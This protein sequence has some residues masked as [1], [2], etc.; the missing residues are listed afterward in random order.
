MN[1]EPKTTIKSNEQLWQRIAL[2]AA[3]FSFVVCILLIANYIQI[4][5]ADPVN[6]KVINALV[7][8]LNQNPNDN[9][10]RDQIRELDL[11]SRKAYFTSQWQI[12]A[13]GYMV[14]IGLA[15]IIIA[16]QMISL[17]KKKEP[18]VTTEF[19]ENSTLAQK[20]ARRWIAVFGVGI[21]ALALVFA[22]LSQND[23]NKKF[24]VAA[25]ALKSQNATTDI[26]SAQ[27]E[28]VST[29]DTTKSANVQTDNVTAS[30]SVKAPS[31][32]DSKDNYPNFRGPGGTARAAQKNI[33]VS[34]NGQSGKNVLWKTA[35]PLSGYNSPIIW[36]SKI[37]LT[38]A[39]ATKREVYC[40][41]KNT[42][43]ILWTTPFDKLPSSPG[44]APKVNSETG[45]A[46]STAA[47]DGKGVYAIFP[48][49]DIIG[50]D[51]EGKKLWAQNLGDPQNHYGHASSL[52]VYKDMVIIQF[53]QRNS[54]K[55]MALSTKTGKTVWNTIR[56][57][58]ISWASPIIVNTGKR[59]EIILAAE[60]Y[61]AAY[62]PANG[63]E[64]W[65]IDCISGE[66]GPSVAYANGMVFSVNDY[67]KLA[68]IKLGDSPKIL[69]ESTDF[70]SDIPSPV[71]TDKYVFLVTSYGTVVCY[72]AL[73][74][75]KY[76]DKEMGGNV[77]ASPVITEGK[78]YLLDK[79]GT[80]HIFKADK[81]YVVLGTSPLGENSVCTPAFT[82]ERIYLR[83]DKNL[84]CIGK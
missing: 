49:G 18:L 16:F 43:K 68:A 72:D 25:T 73:T 71:A 3:I 28:N 34:W 62:N 47:S 36:G 81:E 44:M 5:K 17:G 75:Q 46:A 14:L 74:G 67:S 4:K 37:F 9:E 70:L 15:I 1:D 50:L 55:L 41:D 84:Y 76:W 38:G 19:S 8:R 48:N 6:M 78:V 83:G 30:D 2:V 21:V 12:R 13:G 31:E 69:W 24:A 29:A 82:N 80:M 58:K 65:K 33:P 60:P 54:P 7:E 59:T 11:L 45:L 10:L 63:Q 61:V 52:L 22:F 64:L 32:A 40:I 42:G 51:M 35:I 56:P 79:S 23:L 39:N 53:D 66:V 57:V 77:Y 27:T 20:K 26:A